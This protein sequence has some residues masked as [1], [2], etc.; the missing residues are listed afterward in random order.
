MG[1]RTAA[2]AIQPPLAERTASTPTAPPGSGTGQRSEEARQ[3]ALLLDGV[4]QFANAVAHDLKG[5]LAA[6]KINVQGMQRSLQQGRAMEPAALSERLARVETA[7]TQATDQ[8][9]DLRSRLNATLRQP[10]PIAPTSCDLVATI[11]HVVN[12]FAHLPAAYRLLFRPR[13]SQLIGSWDQPRLTAA[14]AELIGNACKFMPDGGEVKVSTTT[15]A[16]THGR[17]AV[18]TVWDGGIGIPAADLSH[19][20]ELFYRA[21]N[22]VGRY[23]G[24]GLGLYEVRSTVLQHGGSIN[25]SSQ[26][27]HG[28]KVVVRLPLG[29]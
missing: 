24:A 22:V 18:V 14:F 13:Q 20:C 2:G 17:S 27:D 10:P 3:Y 16:A 25:L 28:C 9:G 6:I 1:Q 11:R 15:H 23:R 5:P 4:E 8:I 7:V 19:V 21:E 29:N 12:G 26:L